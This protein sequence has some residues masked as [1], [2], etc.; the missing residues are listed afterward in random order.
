MQADKDERE[1]QEYIPGAGQT[2]LN[3]WGQL[4]GDLLGEYMQQAEL[5]DRLSKEPLEPG[6]VLMVN[7]VGGL[8][9]HYGVYIGDGRVIH[10]AARGSDFGGEISIHETSLEKFRGDSK[11]VYPLDFPDEAGI[12]T[13]RIPG[14]IPLIGDGSGEVEF[15]NLVRSGSYHLY[16]PEETVERAKSRLGESSYSLPL[17]NCEHFAI[18]CKTGVH[19]SHQVNSWGSLLA[20]WITSKIHEKDA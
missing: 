1:L 9:Q 2:G 8:Y 4:F 7:R 3:K 14:G 16:S 10:Y 6:D 12:P 11:Y 5:A 17:N 18:W 19:E 15:F 20:R 13:R